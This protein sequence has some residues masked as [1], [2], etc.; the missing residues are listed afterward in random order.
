MWL[1]AFG[2]GGADRGVRVP[3]GLAPEVQGR[4]LVGP[5]GR[6]STSRYQYP[7]A[8]ERGE[9]C[10]QTSNAPERTPPD[11][12]AA[13]ARWTVGGWGDRG[14]YPTRPSVRV[15]LPSVPNRKRGGHHVVGEDV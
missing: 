12:G 6:W 2:Q 9:S 7:V 11:D 10:H 3:D 5:D 4:G 8:K 1:H 13:P 15:D 14:T